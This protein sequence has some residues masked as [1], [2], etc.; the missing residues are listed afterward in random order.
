M[1]LGW[2]PLKLC[3]ARPIV[4]RMTVRRKLAC[5]V[6]GLLL[7]SS[8]SAALTLIER[9][10]AAEALAALRDVQRDQ[11]RVANVDRSVQLRWREVRVLVELTPTAAQLAVLQDRLTTLDADVRGLSGMPMAASF[12]D[13]FAPVMISWLDVASNLAAGR[14]TPVPASPDAPLAALDR[15][16]QAAEVLASEATVAFLSAQRGADRTSL[17][18]LIVAAVCGGIVVAMLSVTVS[19][20]L[21][22]LENASRHM[23]SGDYAY[24]IPVAHQDE[25]GRA[26]AT[27]NRMAEQLAAAIE[28][29]E[30]AR[31]AAEEASAVK[32]RF[33]TSMSHD[34]RTPL[35][36]VLGYID[37]IEHDVRQA[38]LIATL[39]DVTQLRK[40]TLTLH[41][42]AGELLDLAKLEAGRMPVTMQTVDLSGLVEDMANAL[43]PQLAQRG[44]RLA[45][46]CGDVTSVVTD[47]AKLQHVLH[48]L[49]GNACKF[50]DQGEIA[51]SLARQVGATGEPGVLL[52]VRDTGIGMTDE[53]AAR[54]FEPYEQANASVRARYGGT[55]LGLAIARGYVEV[56]QGTIGVR[57]RPG[58]GTRFTVW[59]PEGGRP[60]DDESFEAEA[61]EA[62]DFLATV[63]VHPSIRLSA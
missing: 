5:G 12:P 22:T 44:N 18:F 55:G 30:R 62:A 54:V 6:A 36:A 32:S 16:H 34:L 4:R 40:C 23:A 26:A 39:D 14:P 31:Q 51:I 56:L 46:D 45:V 15:I 48:N 38:G 59:I 50:T 33:L 41:A 20:G 47:A 2:G 35:T 57:S 10:R 11:Q 21:A 58:R 25:F 53:E 43:Q 7:L 27:F 28:E 63:P 19:Q 29:A 13:D 24:R 49:V 42:M 9:Y 8:G 61:R 37:F 52:T 1:A 17:A 60:V 3:G